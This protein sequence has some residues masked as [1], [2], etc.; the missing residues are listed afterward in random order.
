MKPVLEKYVAQL[1]EEGVVTKEEVEAMKQRVWGIL[2]AGFEKAKNY[3]SNSAEWVSNPW[4]G[5]YY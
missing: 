5:N 1:I 3:K 2:E 4:P